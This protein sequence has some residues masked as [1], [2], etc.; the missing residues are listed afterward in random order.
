MR[1]ADTGSSP[2]AE[3]PP[4]S[5][6]PASAAPAAPSQAPPAPPKR[7]RTALYAVLAVVVVGVLLLLM[8]SQVLSLSSSSSSNS[9]P[10]TY[11][12]A[13]P[14]ADRAVGGYEG[15]G[16][17]LLVAAGVDSAAAVSVPVN[18]SAA[19]SENCTLTLASG[20]NTTVSVPA[21]SGNRTAGVA[22]AWEFLY[23]NSD[24][25]VAVVTVVNGG[26]TVIGTI[27]GRTCTS[28]FGL[29]SPVPSTVI[30]SSQ[31]G[32]A[33]ASDAAAFLAEYPN[34]SARFGLIGGFSLLGLSSVG[35]EWGVAYS[36]CPVGASVSGTGTEFNATVNATDGQVI[37]HE[38]RTG[39]SCASSSSLEVVSGSNT[40]PVEK[41]DATK[42]SEEA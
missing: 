5:S 33:V 16:W 40:I 23:R 21:F 35:A 4:P 27:G 15:G 34:A 18:S 11:S 24:G 19:G 9:G 30:D 29:F 8:G 1:M 32:A 2:W 14:I 13:R 38:T 10:L 26:A 6:P 7:N 12:E 17:A 28:L 31:A 42:R 37:Y 41:A 36:T 25:V 22:P 20:A 39:V 3:V